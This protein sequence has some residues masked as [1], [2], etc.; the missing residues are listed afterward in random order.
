MDV[1][2]KT[3]A[4]LR[5][6]RGPEPWTG[7]MLAADLALAAAVALL[8]LGVEELDSGGPVRMALGAAAVFPLVLLRRRLPAATLVAAAAVGPFL[9]G[10]VLV[11]LPLGWSAGRRI[12][13]AGRALAAFVLAFLASV[14]F[15]VLEQW[16]GMRP[17]LVVVFTTL[18]F[19]VTTVMP[20]LASRYWSQRRTLLQA[21]QE[22]NG[23][24]LRERAMVAGQARLRERQRIA[25]DMHD[26]LGHQLALISVHT[27]ALEVDPE[28]TDRQREAVGV[29]RQASVS[30]MHELREAVGILRDGV[31]APAPVEEAQPAARGVAGIAGIVEAARSAGTDVRLGTAGRPRPLAAACD[32][33]AYRIVQEAL[34]NAYKHAPGAAIAVELRYEDDSLVV[35]VANGPAPAAAAGAVVSGGQGLTGLRERARLVGGMVHAGATGDGGFRIAGVL[36]YGAEPAGAEDA[37]DD[38]GQQERGFAGAPPMD[39]AAVDRELAAGGRSRLGGLALGCGIAV[40]SLVAL[41]IVFAAMVAL[42]IGSANNAM[43]SRADYDRVRVG[44]SE[45]AVRDRLP[46]GDSFLTDGLDRKGPP[47]PEGSEC[48]A[49]M[50]VDDSD[51]GTDTVFR[52]CFKDGKLVDKQSYEAEQ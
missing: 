32:H 36:P 18:M 21:L 9:P 26:S 50:S 42:F 5:W 45:Q 27:G 1:T 23:Q 52:F 49:L 3:R 35:E 30:A 24:L 41:L 17:L 14:G 46:D 33:A 4:G 6:L 20:G 16:A 8:G 37:A 44:D 28:L 43:I 10:T 47:R 11:T 22:R 48:L 25:Q 38:F 51:F 31:E 12:V 15:G 19:L 13:G 39:W 40:A 7:R 2:A 34:T 29:L